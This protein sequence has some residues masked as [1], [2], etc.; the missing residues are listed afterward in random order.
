MELL[1]FG[2]EDIDNVLAQMS[3]EELDALPF[4]AIQLD[5]GGRVITYNSV[6]A[7]ITGR[8]PEDVL[9]RNFFEEIAPCTNTP[10]FH[11][12][13]KDGVAAGVLNQ[14]FEYTFDYRMVPTKVDVHMKLAANGSSCWIFVKRVTQSV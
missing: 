12:K 10:D 4:G 14:I 3:P 11:G 1:R 2:S 6:E 9:G 13:F 7:D 5:L 8:E